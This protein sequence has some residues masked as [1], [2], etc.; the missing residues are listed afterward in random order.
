MS[1]PKRLRILFDGIEIQETPDG[2]QD[3]TSRISRNKDINSIFIT[4][5]AELTFMDDGYDYLITKFEE[6]F[7]NS[8]E[9]ELQQYC[10]GYYHSFFKGIIFISSAEVDRKNCTIKIQIEDNSFYAKINNNKSIEVFP[11]AEQS[12]NG[13]VIAVCPITNVNL[14][15]PSDGS[16]IGYLV[17]PPYSAAHYRV[18]DLFEYLITF[19]TDGTVEFDSVV[20]GPAGAYNGLMVT[21]GKVLSQYTT[22]GTT[23]AEF[24]ENFPKISFDQL[25]KEVN[26]KVHI[27]MYVDYSGTLPKIRIERV[28]DTRSEATSFRAPNIDELKE[29]IFYDELYS[30]VRLGSSEVSDKP[31]NPPSIY[32]SF[33]E[34]ISF[35]GFKEEQFLVLGECNIDKEL[36]LVSDWIISSNIIEDCLIN[37]ESD[38][39]DE[40]IFVMCDYLYGNFY[41]AQDNL[42]GQSGLF[43]VFYNLDLNGQA[44]MD[45]YFGAVPLSIAQYLGNADNTFRASRTSDMQPVFNTFTNIQPQ[46]D[47]TPPN[48]DTGGNYNPV[49]GRYT[50]P[51][52][53]LYTF[54]LYIR[55]WYTPINSIAY[56]VSYYIEQYNSGN[57]LIRRVLMGTL[58]TQAG[59]VDG[60]FSKTFIGSTG[61]YFIAVTSDAAF[62]AGT[63]VLILTNSYFACVN[64]VDG[65]GIYK[66]FDPIDYPVYHHEWEYPLTLAEYTNIERNQTSQLEFYRYNEKHYSGWIHDIKYKRFGDE[67]AKFITYR[68]KTIPVTFNQD[69]EI[70]NI[71]MI[72]QLADITYDLSIDKDG[73]PG[74]GSSITNRMFFY[75]ANSYATFTVPATFLNCDFLFYY[76]TRFPSVGGITATFIYTT[77]GTFLI[78]PGCNYII[79]IT[80][81][82]TQVGDTWPSVLPEITAPTSVGA[83][84][85]ANIRLVNPAILAD[86]T[87]LWSTGA[88]TQSINEP[89]GDYTCL[90]TYVPGT[91][92]NN[93][94]LFNINIPISDIGQQ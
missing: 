25:W 84:G 75:Y 85:T 81:D 19:M 57:S 22:T 40:I 70:R 72:G 56:G 9:V 32:Q 59:Y 55:E 34:D 11:F 92:D 83:N 65:G 28:S 39:D 91:F 18:Y 33:P 26:K 37:G 67:K 2:W 73:N 62:T 45:N 54:E 1:E 50:A 21:C 78:E 27:G 63:L 52:G 79:Q 90:V 4:T 14:F 53:G 23:E 5:D 93:S 76:I 87:F 74:G 94:I 3:I 20:F 47:F 6:S 88:T 17:S 43:P 61:D 16:T 31:N 66:D 42:E 38:Y 30:T 69:P 80:Y 49:N 36:D 10:D 41:A 13:D 8:V 82:L 7:C 89:A 46:D 24:K 29:K 60:T 51:Q 35:V 64:S 86:Y 71:H 48:Y 12:K 68:A 15:D 77:T 44:V 58:F